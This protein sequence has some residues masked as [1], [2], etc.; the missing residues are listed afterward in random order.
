MIRFSAESSHRVLQ[1]S[2][3]RIPL[4]EHEDLRSSADSTISTSLIH[5]ITSAG[6]C[7][8]VLNLIFHQRTLLTWGICQNEDLKSAIVV[9]LAN[10]SVKIFPH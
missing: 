7:A 8:S 10:N 4:I 1:K 3:V 6:N 2:G 9:G 5:S